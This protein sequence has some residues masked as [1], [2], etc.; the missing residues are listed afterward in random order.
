MND[1]EFADI[2]YLTTLSREGVKKCKEFEKLIKIEFG[3]L[4]SSYRFLNKYYNEVT[5]DVPTFLKSHLCLIYNQQFG[6]DYCRATNELLGDESLGY[7]IMLT[8]EETIK[9]SVIGTDDKITFNKYVEFAKYADEKYD[10]FHDKMETLIEEENNYYEEWTWAFEKLL[11][12]SGVINEDG[13]LGLKIPTNEADIVVEYIQQHAK[14]STFINGYDNCLEKNLQVD[15]IDDKLKDMEEG[16]GEVETEIT[17]E[18]VKELLRSMC[19]KDTEEDSEN[20]K[21]IDAIENEGK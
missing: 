10:E 14:M 12:T 7:N 19:D 16:L 18:D 8:D 5:K 9:N 15:K 3:N 1:D 13:Q 2:P 17:E 21:N 6:E 20:N 11:E 4:V